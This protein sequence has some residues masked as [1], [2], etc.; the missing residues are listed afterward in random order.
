MVAKGIH[1]SAVWKPVIC[2]TTQS[3]DKMI[4]TFNEEVDM[5][6]FLQQFPS[7]IFRLHPWILCLIVSGVGVG[8]SMSDSRAMAETTNVPWECSEYSGDAQTRC[9]TALMELQQEKIDKLA[10][11]LKAQEGTVSQLKE[12]L[13]RQEALALSQVQASKQDPRYPP[14]PYVS[15]YAL[16]YGYA[17]PPIGIYLQPPWRYPSYYGYGPRF[18]PGYW[19]SPGLSFNFRFGGG[20]HHHHR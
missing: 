11:Q 12:K 9:I 7:K 19:G 3:H 17:S 13:D 14:P 15:A 18:G 2:R 1:S 4:Y 8:L 5:N 16:P 6:T 10:E 20:H